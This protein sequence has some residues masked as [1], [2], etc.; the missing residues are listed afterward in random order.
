VTAEH[1]GIEMKKKKE[2]IR[3]H[4]VSFVTDGRFVSESEHGNEKKR[5]ERLKHLRQ[6][7]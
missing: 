1:R 2:E 4:K 3:Q 7:V 5:N 6:I